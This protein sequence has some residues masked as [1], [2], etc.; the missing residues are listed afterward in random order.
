LQASIDILALSVREVLELVVFDDFRSQREPTEDRGS[1]CW[2]TSEEQ[3]GFGREHSSVLVFLERA[4][5]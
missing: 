5:V 3:T 2:T 4:A 1:L